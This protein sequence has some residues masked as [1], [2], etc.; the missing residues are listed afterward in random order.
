MKIDA[1]PFLEL[2]T[3]SNQKA[4]CSRPVFNPQ[5][6]A[7][8]R[9]EG[10]QVVKSEVTHRVTVYAPIPSEVKDNAVV[11]IDGQR[12][13]IVRGGVASTRVGADLYLAQEST[14]GEKPYVRRT[15]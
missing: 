12:Y 6:V 3:A 9:S 1:R 2:V 13:R 11:S 7:F 14:Q 8:G 10:G 4:W 15:P 5:S